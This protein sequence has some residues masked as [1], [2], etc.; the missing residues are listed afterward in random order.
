[1]IVRK[2]YTI[3]D[4]HCSAC[5]MRLEGLEDDLPGIR[6]IKASYQKQKLEVEFDEK[7]VSEQEIIRAISAMDYQVVEE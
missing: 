7:Q 6:S 2:T 1:M 4:M 3:P 5:V